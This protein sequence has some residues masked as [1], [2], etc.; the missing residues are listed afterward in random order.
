MPTSS[1]PAPIAAT[2]GLST[3]I[4]DERDR[5]EAAADE[6]EERHVVAAD[7][8]VA[9]PAV[10]ARRGPARLARS[11]ATDA[12]AIVKLSSAPNEYT[13]PSSVSCPGRIS[14][15]AATEKTRMP[16]HGVRK[17]GCRRRSASGIW[18]WMPIE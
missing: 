2:C 8:H 14:T 12:C 11:R 1:Q 16:I 7:L 9:G 17:R 15:I 3:T 6:R 4:D 13:L 18:R 10:R 5:R